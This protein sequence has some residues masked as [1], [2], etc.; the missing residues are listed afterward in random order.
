MLFVVPRNGV[1]ENCLLNPYLGLIGESCSVGGCK[2][3]SSF[4]GLGTGSSFLVS[5]THLAGTSNAFIDSCRFTTVLLTG[6]PLE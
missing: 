6:I 1:L 3:V 4:V 5:T 2:F